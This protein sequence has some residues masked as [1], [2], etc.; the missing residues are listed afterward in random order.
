[1]NVD[2]LRAKCLRWKNDPSVFPEIVQ[3]ACA[4]FGN[5]STLA[6]LT[7][8]P[9]SFVAAWAEGTARPY[10]SFERAIVEQ[11][12]HEATITLQRRD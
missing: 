9:E 1:M 12:L 10:P 5:V 4:F 7:G 11:L 6:C 8:M 3:T 2:S